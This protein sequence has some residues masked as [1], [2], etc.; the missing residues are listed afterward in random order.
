MEIKRG[1]IYQLGK[2][3]LMVGDS[4]NPEDVKKLLAGETADLIFTDPP[5]GINVQKKDGTIG[6]GNAKT[7]PTKF[8]RMIGDDTGVNPIF[9][10]QYSDKVFIWGGNYFAHQLPKGGR[11]FVWDKNRP[12]GT[13]FSDCELAWSNLKGVKVTKCSCTWN[14]FIKEGESGKRIHPSQKPI[15][16]FVEILTEISQPG[17]LILDLFGGSGSTLIACDKIDRTCYLMEIDPYYCQVIIDRW[18][19]MTGIEPVLVSE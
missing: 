1:Q 14:G 8:K 15:K 13:D 5:Y 12:K 7:P 16:L 3:R 17:W 6:G 19:K 4:T 11:W 9:C 18:I 2:H 10:L